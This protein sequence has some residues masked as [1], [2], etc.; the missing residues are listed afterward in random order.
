[1]RID[2][3]QLKQMARE[4]IAGAH[5]SARLV[6]L[7]YILLTT[8]L[9]GVIQTFMGSPMQTVTELIA[10]GYDPQWAIYATFSTVSLPLVAF[11]SILL[12][13]YNSVMSFGYV[14]YCLRLS[15]N[16]E[17]AGYGTLLEGFS[18]VG[19][20]ILTHILVAV[21]TFLWGLALSIPFVII[22]GLV[23]AFGGALGVLLFIVLYIAF[24]VGVL[25]FA[26][27]YVMADY[28]LF[29]NPE[30]GCLEAISTSKELMQGR[31]WEYVVLGL[32]F[33]GWLLLVLV[34]SGIGGAIG[35]AIGGI[36]GSEILGAWIGLIVGELVALPLN[37]WLTPYMGC[38]FAHYYNACSGNG[39]QPENRQ[40]PWGEA[41]SSGNSFPR[42]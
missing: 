28:C 7:V 19:R 16:Q 27:R 37:L 36:G 24:F 21:F 6:T 11:V 8:V 12:A 35:S 39:N 20:V 40:D 22:G 33:L 25:Y 3:P 34:L 31:K 30:G 13:L 42:L 1:M 38:T 4:N 2:R 15:H 9:T 41:P 32:S 29:D 26:L 14:A 5:P 23:I 18:M 17:H 10:Q